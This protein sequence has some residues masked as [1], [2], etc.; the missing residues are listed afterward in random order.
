M[1]FNVLFHLHSFVQVPHIQELGIF[2][3]QILHH[4]LPLQADKSG[5]HVA[6]ICHNQPIHN[7]FVLQVSFVHIMLLFWHFLKP[8]W[9]HIVVVAVVNIC[10]VRVLKPSFQCF[11]SRFWSEFLSHILRSFRLIKDSTRPLH[12]EMFAQ[13]IEPLHDW[14]VTGERTKSDL[15]KRLFKPKNL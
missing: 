6:L 10:F 9:A 12:S 14:A 15:I 1:W 5:V 11:Q 13:N 7:I 4:V 8:N 3:C 2:H